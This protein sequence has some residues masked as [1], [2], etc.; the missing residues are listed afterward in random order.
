MVIVASSVSGSPSSTAVSARSTVRHRIGVIVGAVVVG[1][2]ANHLLRMHLDTLQR[3]ASTDPIAA[4]RELATEVRFGGLAI[5][6]SVA[7]LLA[8]R[9]GVPTVGR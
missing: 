9:A 7:A 4:R 5:F 3:M 2:V 8:C 1:L 6:T